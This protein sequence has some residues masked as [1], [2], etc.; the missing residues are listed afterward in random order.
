MRTLII[1]ILPMNTKEEETKLEYCRYL[2]G[3]NFCPEYAQK[4]ST[5]EYECLQNTLLLTMIKFYIQMAASTQG[6]KVH[7]YEI[8]EENLLLALLVKIRSMT[9]P[10]LQILN[11]RYS[12]F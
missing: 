7:V 8:R 10:A 1:E 3:G 9:S 4:A 6:K 11:L 12:S 2:Q 5:R